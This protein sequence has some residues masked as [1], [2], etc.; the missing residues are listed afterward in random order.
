[1]RRSDRQTSE[2]E[3][4]D[5]I[6]AAPYGVLSAVDAEGHLSTTPVSPV[7]MDGALY[8]HSTCEEGDRARAIAAHPYV[9]VCFV[10]RCEIVAD[11]YTIDYRSAVVRGTCTR[12]TDREEGERALEA[13]ARHY[14]PTCDAEAT[15]G[16]SES[17]HEKVSVWRVQIE[18]LS[19]KA[20]YPKHPA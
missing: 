7:L 2:E 16:Y 1:M 15:R 10:A 11:L 14:D 13:I 19:G 4:L 17:A 6:N 8:F 18:E 5:I 9:S 20:K 12:V 3:A